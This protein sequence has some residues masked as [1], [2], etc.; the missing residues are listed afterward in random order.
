MNFVLMLGS[1]FVAVLMGYLGATKAPGYFVGCVAF[2]GYFV[3]RI[4]TSW[5]AAK[6][7]GA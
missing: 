2:G 1:L 4:V 5:I 6:K 7:E 3:Y